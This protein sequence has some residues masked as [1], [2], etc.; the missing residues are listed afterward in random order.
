MRNKVQSAIRECR[1]QLFLDTADD[2]RLDVVSSNLGM[3]RSNVNFSDDEWRYAV[4][5]I[6]L[7]GK[8]VRNI[9][10]RALEVI[11]GP[12]KTRIA[13]LDIAPFV[14][15]EIVHFEDSSNL[16]QLGTLI[17][18]PGLTTEET[19]AFCFR[20][21]ETNKVFLESALLFDHAALDPA[22]N[23][24]ESDHSAGVTTLNLVNSNS[25]PTTG[26][27]YPII[28][29]RGT[30]FEETLVVT[31]NNTISDTLTLQNPTMF[32]HAGPKST[33][34]RKPLNAAAPDGRTFL[35]LDNEDTRSFPAA[36]YV[37]LAFGDPGE[38]T[39][40]FIE[41]SIEDD[42]LY[43]RTP[44]IFSHVAGESVELVTPGAE[45]ETCSVIQQGVDW[46]I[47]ETTPNKIIIVVPA[48][49]LT[50]TL[51]DASY[52]HDAV[53]PPYATAL[54]SN[55]MSTDVV[56]EV[57][58]SSGLPVAG[59]VEI[60]GTH[61]FYIDKDD[62][63]DTL[64]LPRDAGIA[65]LAGSTVNL[66]RPVYSGTDLEEGNLRDAFGN[67]QADQFSGPYLFDITQQAPTIV[68][69]RLNETL[70]TP[71]RV[72]FAQSTGNTAI[73]V[74]DVFDWPAPPFTPFPVRIGLGTGFEETTTCIDRTL[75]VG[76][77]TSV[78]GVHPPTTTI[79]AS[80]TTAFPQSN[81]VDPA[82]YRII[83]NQGGPAEEIVIVSSVISG[84]PG[85]FNLVNATV[86]PHT[87]GQSIRLLND[88]LSVDP[89]TQPHAADQINPSVF[90]HLV[91][92]LVETLELEPGGGTQ[93]PDNGTVYLNFGKE[94]L[95][96][97]QKIVSA[98][99][100]IL[101]MSNTSIFPTT[102]FPYKI[103]VG[104][105]LPQEEITSV[106]ANN[107]GLN[108][109]T[110]SPALVGSFAAGDYVV[111][112]A[113]L[114]TTVDYNNKVV[115]VLELST[116][117]GFTS[118]YT[119]GENVVLTG[120]ASEPDISGNSFSFKLPPNPA[121]RI[122]FLFDLIRAAGVEIVFVEDR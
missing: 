95:T 99:P 37:R 16:L 5:E 26:F 109:L 114:P 25:F 88:V 15:E 90:G 38:E 11:L 116:P 72:A 31:A 22:S 43:L 69:S 7:Q 59:I 97:R 23:L 29:D 40:E 112:A 17:F 56:I 9:F 14:D 60:N 54:S 74:K 34:V 47:H 117:T 30:E 33:F 51:R 119:N 3:D 32:D 94:R 104:Q 68:S 79:Q 110:V 121:D 111:F 102:D 53:L 44:L 20:D 71:T 87:T 2:I 42:V 19:V 46:S 118:G 96:V 108:Q 98:T 113:G 100:T 122:N 28:V 101:T 63:T 81:G 106:T 55:L 45:V 66:V 1:D 84:A 115:D 50:I 75:R 86:F 57:V 21:L 58:D 41:N 10:Y 70:P 83:I 73:E 107:T 92:K 35:Q 78:L 8:Q 120:G 67:I 62:T 93:F 105:G 76:T 39:I 65:A 89:L 49:S 6:A 36:G 12:Q 91:E 61:I 85:F 4:K 64:F 82:G 24:L 52:L 48:G 27:P 80:D 13:N 18:D 103:V 77:T